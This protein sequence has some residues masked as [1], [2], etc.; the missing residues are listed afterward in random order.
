[1]VKQYAKMRNFLTE[2]AILSEDG[3][4]DY[5]VWKVYLRAGAMLTQEKT[6]GIR[7]MVGHLRHAAE[8]I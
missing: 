6:V 8:V 3:T 1:M 4:M 5:G 7:S 2:N